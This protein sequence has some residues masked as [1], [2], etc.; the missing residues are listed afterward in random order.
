MSYSTSILASSHFCNNVQTLLLWLAWPANAAPADPLPTLP[1]TTTPAASCPPS[2]PEPRTRSTAEWLLAAIDALERR[3]RIAPL[4]KFASAGTNVALSLA[5]SR[6]NDAV[7]IDVV[8][9]LLRGHAWA[10]P[11]LRKHN[12]G[13]IAI[14]SRCT[15]PSAIAGTLFG[16][17][18]RAPGHPEVYGPLL[19][20]LETRD[21]RPS[22]LATG[23]EGDVSEVADRRWVVPGGA[24]AGAIAGGDPGLA[25]DDLGS[26][27]T[28]GTVRS[29]TGLQAQRAGL[30][31]LGNTCYA[32]AAVQ[33]LFSL[34]AFRRGVLACMPGAGGPC[35]RT[36]RELFGLLVGSRR[37]AQ[38]PSAFLAACR[39]EWF[40]AGTQ[41]DSGEFLVHWLDQLDR[42]LQGGVKAAKAAKSDVSVTP[43]RLLTGAMATMIRCL[44]C[45]RESCRREAFTAL[46]LPITGEGEGVGKLLGG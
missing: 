5:Q 25:V 31:N 27:S 29:I 39:P 10:V 8:A 30:V 24:F 36:T 23:A 33:A 40:P 7:L 2:W 11:L 43:P 15:R 18:Q 37:R 4:A 45:Q 28:G 13:L 6:P 21:C 38:R 3:D 19:Q 41:Q 16:I 20:A 44:A 1:S 17:M 14:I 35:T 34:T 26:G 22:P 12:R 32:N 42:E 9:R 46:P